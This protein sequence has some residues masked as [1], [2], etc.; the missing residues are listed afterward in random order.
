MANWR[1]TRTPSIYVAHATSCPANLDPKARCRCDPSYRGRRRNPLTGRPEWQKPVVKN[2]AE[3]LSWLSASDD[4]PPSTTAPG[5]KALEPLPW[6]RFVMLLK[7][8]LGI[9]DKSPKK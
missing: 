3:V 1:K 8:L 5:V 2:R 7:S 4:P 6:E 9:G